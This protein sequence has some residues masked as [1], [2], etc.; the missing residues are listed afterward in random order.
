VVDHKHTWFTEQQT[1]HRF[2]NACGEHDPPN[3]NCPDR[4]SALWRFLTYDRNDGMVV[5]L[6]K[7]DN[8]GN[9]TAR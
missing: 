7:D 9:N 1:N 4:P 6:R 8:R 2:C 3:A 5:V